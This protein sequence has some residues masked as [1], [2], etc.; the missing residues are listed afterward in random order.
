MAR[1]PYISTNLQA[2]VGREQREKT[3]QFLQSAGYVEHLPLIRFAGYE[4]GGRAVSCA[5]VQLDD[6]DALAVMHPF[7]PNRP[8]LFFGKTIRLTKAALSWRVKT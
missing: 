5:L 2:D 4:R 7:E 6:P 8:Q 1:Q 3:A